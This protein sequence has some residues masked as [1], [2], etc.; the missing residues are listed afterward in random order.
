MKITIS[1]KGDVWY[2]NV[3]DGERIVKG[4][5]GSKEWA[6]RNAERWAKQYG[7][8]V[9]VEAQECMANSAI[10]VI[11]DSGGDV[12]SIRYRSA[13]RQDIVMDIC[14]SLRAWWCVWVVGV[15]GR[16]RSL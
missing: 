5:A 8:G 7:V 15:D 10:C 9:Y 11:G 3:M 6:E 14:R 16:L 1:N 4:V 12:I 13:I 2:A